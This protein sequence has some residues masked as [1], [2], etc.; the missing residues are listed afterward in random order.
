MLTLDPRRPVA[1]AIAVRDGRVMA[2]GGR[3][4]MRALAGARAERVDVGGATVMPG[5]LDP[6]LHLYALAARAAHL[7][8]APLDSV[9]AVLAA[10]RRAA[11]RLAPGA[12][13]RAEGLD[14]TRLERLPTAA[15]L[16]RVA[17]RHPVRLRHRNRHASVLSGRALALLGGGAG[18]ERRDGR[19][20]GLVAG[21]EVALGRLVGPLPDR[22]FADGLAAAGRELSGLGLTTVAD[23]TPRGP[24]LLGPLRAA[25]IGG[26][27]PQRVFAMRPVGV[28]VWRETGR[29][30]P[31]PVKILVEEGRC[32]LRP[33]A[34]L[35]AGRIAR[36]AR[37]GDTVAVH[38]LGAATLVVVLAAF[39]ALPR[40]ARIGRRHRL[41]HLA[42]CPPV[43][44]DPIARLGLGVVTNP[45]FVHWRGDVYRAETPPPAHGWLY[46]ARSLAAAGVPLAGA[47][48]APV[49]P[50]SPW[51]GLAAARSRRTARG[52]SLG[53]AERLRAGAALALFTTGAAW[54]LGDDALGRLVP[55]GPADLIA[56]EPDPL[57]APADEVATARVRLTLVDGVRTWPP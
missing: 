53:L 29:L 36:A 34:R 37:A 2:V 19:P 7:D 5:L 39:A 13:V 42:E 20:T 48:D 32:G 22:V 12:W 40:G 21:R 45:A 30:R 52:V 56:V 33:S 24:R 47:S 46:R 25:M 55:G 11:A 8:L 31:G 9:A 4:E 50:V 51:V 3:A 16:D 57:R 1:E 54:A 10:V 18:I 38:C 41:E 28:P 35:L 6:H 14:D 23:A 26:A 49:V 15:E 43:L 27:L 17:P 44:V